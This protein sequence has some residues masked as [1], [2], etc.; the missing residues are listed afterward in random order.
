MIGRPTTVTRRHCLLLLGAGLGTAVLGIW[1]AMADSLADAKAA[2]HVGERPDGYLGAAPGAPAAAASLV[3]EINA[4]RKER[5]AAIAQRNK[6]PVAAVEALAGQ[7]LVQEAP[8]GAW[9]MDAGG[10]WQRK[11]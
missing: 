8:S 3:A 10:N 1:P 4:R 9:V 11:P 2:G 5:Y 6:V 7:R